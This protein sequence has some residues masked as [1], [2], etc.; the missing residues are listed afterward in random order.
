[1]YGFFVLLRVLMFRTP[2]LLELTSSHQL[3]T[4]ASKPSKTSHLM[5]MYVLCRSTT[6]RDRYYRRR[7]SLPRK[8]GFCFGRGM[9]CRHHDER[10]LCSSL[11]TDISRGFAFAAPSNRDSISR[12]KA[13]KNGHVFP[14]ILKRNTHQAGKR[15]L[16]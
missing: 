16:S 3:R 10:Q 2:L 7:C 9:K 1:M 4:L 11:V 8:S 5:A 15:L 13:V 12:K 6:A 14:K